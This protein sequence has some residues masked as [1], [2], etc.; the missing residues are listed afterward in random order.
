MDTKLDTHKKLMLSIKFREVKMSMEYVG[1]QLEGLGV[2]LSR[3]K[4]GHGEPPS[5][6][7]YVQFGSLPTH[8][9]EKKDVEKKIK[10]RISVFN[11]RKNR[12]RF[13]RR[14][15]ELKGENMD[16]KRLDSELTK[17]LTISSPEEAGKYF[18]A[19]LGGM[20]EEEF[21]VSFLN[22]KN[23][24]IETH[25]LSCKN[26]NTTVIF[27]REILKIAI[28][29]SCSK[30]VLAH[31][32]VSEYIVPSKDDIDIT[33]R[34]L[35]I[36]QPLDINVLDL[37]IVRSITEYISLEAMDYMPRWEQEQANYE[38]I[39]IKDS[40]IDYRKAYES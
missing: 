27:P 9:V 36:L 20:T 18:L 33:R 4:K 22:E 34:I 10:L 37:I 39:E 11:Y 7:L 29:C 40:G 35:N 25:T 28:A 24:I 5:S 13:K 3:I 14:D 21:L 12:S 32:Y 2:I 30:I 19:K 16:V 8:R 31:N 38:P 23:Q 26:M 6:E 17:E 1:N 15:G